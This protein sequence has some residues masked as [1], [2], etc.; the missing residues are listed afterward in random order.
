MDNE[1]YTRPPYIQAAREVMGGIE[2]DPASCAMANEIVK[3]ERYYDK[4]QNG[5]LQ[6]W[7]AKSL[8]L[9][10]PYAKIDGY[11]SGIRRWIEKA[12]DSYRS[13]QVEQAIL[14]VTTEVN[15]QWFLPLWNY[16]ICF[17]DHRVKFIAPHRNK[18]GVYS[19]MFGAC[20]VYLGANEDVFIEV[21]SR[22][23]HVVRSLRYRPVTSSAYEQQPLLDLE[24]LG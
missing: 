10:P 20:F 3:A 24:A 2:L 14:L 1:W 16:P 5:L 19:H 8:W 18:R 4:E 12:L 13:G 23:G 6:A 15:A 9:N 21:F 7:C 11:Q 22:F 17:A